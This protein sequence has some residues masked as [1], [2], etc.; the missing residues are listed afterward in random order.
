MTHLPELI[1]C[2]SN[3]LMYSKQATAENIKNASEILYFSCCFSFYRGMVVYI[4]NTIGLYY[5]GQLTRLIYVPLL[6]VNHIQ[7]IHL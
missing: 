6:N 2:V 7:Y 4:N 1:Q 3:Y 5:N